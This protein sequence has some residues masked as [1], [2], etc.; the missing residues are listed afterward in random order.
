MSN[1]TI[2]VDMVTLEFMNMWPSDMANPPT[3]IGPNPQVS[4]ETSEDPTVLMA[5]RDPETGE[6]TLQADP[7]KIED[8]KAAL[9]SQLRTERNRRLAASDWTQLVDSHLSQEK[10]DAWAA[11]R[12]ELRDLPDEVTDPTQVEW[13]LDPTQQV[14]VPPVTGSRLDGIL[15]QV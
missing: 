10:K 7:Q 8:H 1:T 14:P 13:P 12:Q 3:V 11:Y 4:L 5:V 2:I 9:W 6:I 15:G